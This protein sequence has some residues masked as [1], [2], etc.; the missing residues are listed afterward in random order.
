MPVAAA[1]SRL[2]TLDEGHNLLREP[3]HLLE[4]RTELKQQKIN[5]D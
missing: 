1:R 5:S 2:N 4:L 3:F